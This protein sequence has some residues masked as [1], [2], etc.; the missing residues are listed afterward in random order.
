MRGSLARLIYAGGVALSISLV[1]NAALADKIKH[2]IAVFTGLDKITGRIIAF[3]VATDETVQFGSLQITE[4]VCYTRPAT[5][6]PQTTTFIEVDEVD[7]ANQYKRIFSGW[8]FAS[9]PGLHGIEH[10]IYDIWLTGCKGGGETVTSPET[11]E[12]EPAAPPPPPENAKPPA[13]KPQRQRRAQPVDDQ[14]AGAPGLDRAASTPRQN[15]GP[16]EVGPPPGLIP[17]PA[18]A[19]PQDRSYPPAPGNGGF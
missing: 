8:M 10:P 9:S 13:Q 6:T 5:E 19:Q 15:R 18:R 12:A 3:E 7:A 2:P 1:S 11:S 4:R 17:P 14:G 16:I